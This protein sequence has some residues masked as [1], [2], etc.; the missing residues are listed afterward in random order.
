MLE[1]LNTFR[2]TDKVLSCG[3]YPQVLPRWTVTG[4]P[5]QRWISRL[6]SSPTELTR[7]LHQYR[8]CVDFLLNKSSDVIEN[9]HLDL[10]F[11]A[12]FL[13]TGMSFAGEVMDQHTEQNACFASPPKGRGLSFQG[14]PVR[15]ITADYS[16]DDRLFHANKWSLFEKT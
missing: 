1:T 13:D 7:R 8:L 6:N 10:S 14:D 5:T 15:V 3:F 2:S 9:Y 4:D 16:V 11:P 12:K